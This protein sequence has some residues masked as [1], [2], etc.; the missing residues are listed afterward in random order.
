MNLPDDYKVWF[1]HYVGSEET[2]ELRIWVRDQAKETL[3]HTYPS[4]EIIRQTLT[5]S[6]YESSVFPGGRI[7]IEVTIIYRMQSPFLPGV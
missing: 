6:P 5:S 3:F 4:A 7:R 1:Y 2:P